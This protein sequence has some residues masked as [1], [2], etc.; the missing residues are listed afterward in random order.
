[1]YENCKCS[2]EYDK[3]I[4]DKYIIFTSLQ[5]TR[6]PLL[7]IP[8]FLR[9]IFSILYHYWRKDFDEFILKLKKGVM[10]FKD[11]DSWNRF[12]EKSL[13]PIEKFYSKLQYKG[14]S[15]VDYRPA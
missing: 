13:A 5:C 10:S 9:S 12:N 8:N 6:K 15:N 7:I 3:L 14:I 1:M 4:K 2:L 11:I